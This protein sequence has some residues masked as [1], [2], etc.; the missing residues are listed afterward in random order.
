MKPIAKASAGLNADELKS[1][2]LIISSELLANLR[3]GEWKSGRLLCEMAGGSV[4][5][6]RRHTRQPEKSWQRYPGLT[7]EHENGEFQQTM[8][9]VLRAEPPLDE[10]PLYLPP[11]LPLGLKR[12]ETESGGA[13][14]QPFLEK[15]FEKY[16][17]ILAL[18]EEDACLLVARRSTVLLDR[19]WYRHEIVE[20]PPRAAEAGSDP[21][22]QGAKVAVIGLGSIG[23][24]AA[25][26]L[27]AA[28]AERL[29]LI[30]PDRLE[31]R[32]LRRHLCLADDVGCRKVDA[33][34]AMLA[35][36]GLNVETEQYA[37][38]VPRQDSDEIR[39]AIANC[40]LILCCTDSAPA[41]HYANHLARGLEIP[42]VIASI[43]LMPEA[44][45]EV[46]LAQP[47]EQGCL[48]CWRLKLEAEKVMMRAE[49]YDPADYPGPT[50]ETPVGV[51]AY[52]LDQLAAMACHLASESTQGASPRVWLNALQTEVS[53]FQ[54][55]K[56]Q[57]PLIEEVVAVSNCRVCG[58][59]ER[60]TS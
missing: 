7:V 26:L 52:H 1:E 56:V 50:Q 28:G 6:A 27:A 3:S 11:R 60:A 59:N 54:D 13:F 19:V 53:N 16:E 20:V 24:R 58:G 36:A 40:D 32:N 34:S 2:M 12:L 21:R 4:L 17:A 35:R 14:P 51:P 44:L 57:R 46:V 43:K 39:K 49:T 31:A 29:V 9:G 47:R 38:G 45:G 33:V 22:L 5:L 18:G 30:D 25:W 8:I 48:N 37:S 41:Q 15:M 42:A 10:S 23:S 55:L